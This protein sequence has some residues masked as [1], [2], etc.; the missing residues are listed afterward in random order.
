M[1]CAV[2]FDEIEKLKRQFEEMQRIAEGPMRQISEHQDQLEAATKTLREL[3][4]PISV[5]NFT[6]VAI[7]TQ[8]IIDKMSSRLFGLTEEMGRA[9]VQVKPLD[10][11]FIDETKT[12]WEQARLGLG[13]GEDTRLQL[14]A[15][16]KALANAHTLTAGLDTQDWALGVKG[17]L[18]SVALSN[19]VLEG[20]TAPDSIAS[21]T[22]YATELPQLT[23]RR[24]FSADPFRDMVSE[25][26]SIS[27]YLHA[28]ELSLRTIEEA[29]I[30]EL[31][32]PAHEL[33]DILG[34]S[35]FALGQRHAE[36][37]ASFNLSDGMLASVPPFA[38]E[39]PTIDLFVHSSA[40]R[41]ITP[42]RGY[43]KPQDAAAVSL[44]AV[45]VEETVVFLESTLSDL[46]PA[47]LSQYR[48]AKARVSERGPDWWTQGASSMRKLFK[49]V[50]HTA[51]P[52]ELVGPWATK[53]NKQFDSNGKPTRGTKVDWLCE[54][55]PNDH[56]RAFVKT[57]LTSALACIDMIDSSQHVDDYP[58]FEDQYNW[59]LLR[60][61][62]AI[63][64][65]L[66]IWKSRKAN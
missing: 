62:M 7:E 35:T 54:F 12:L 9:L 43:E 48:G 14:E 46:K 22:R 16:A 3:H 38:S 50:L 41:S 55:I 63:R 58:E 28:T 31:I 66:T 20:L 60:V 2:D 51:A 64:H 26:G 42:H 44:R 11:G 37:I 17:I 40:V 6:G 49:G 61:E 19:T 10:F 65:I 53:N 57:E 8:Q 56:Y 25:V 18:S 4:S 33:Q 1:E 47:F 5:D 27:K 13:L 39:L 32:S 30:G 15:G 59:I 52:N 34:R 29:R 24:Q 23:A 21:M 36:L 45:V